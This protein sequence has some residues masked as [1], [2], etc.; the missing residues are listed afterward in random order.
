M[1]TS[2][3]MG[4]PAKYTVDEAANL[5]KRLY[6]IE[7]EVM[8][9][10]GGYLV[11]VYNWELKIALPRH[12]WQ[13]SLRADALR[14]RVL[15]LRYPRRDV[16]Q[17]HDSQLGHF[18]KMLIQCRN[19]AEL[20]QGI[21]FVTKRMLREGYEYYLAHTDHLD[22]GPTIEFMSRFPDVIKLQLEEIQAIYQGLPAADLTWGNTMEAYAKS[23]GGLL[24]I[25]PGALSPSEQ[26]AW[27]KL[28]KRPFYQAPKV[29]HTDP[30]F[31]AAFYHY[32]PRAP[33]N[34]LEDQIWC[35][36]SH[37]NEIWASEVPGLLCWA[38][39]DMP[40]EFYMDTARWAYDESRH[41]MM[42]EERLKAWGFELGVDIPRVSDN[43]ISQ[44]EHG[45]IALL[46]LL[47]AF[48]CNA[49]A[50]RNKQRDRYRMEGDFSSAQD[51]DYDWADESIHMQ[52]GHKW[53]MHKFNND[54]DKVE[55]AKEEAMD[56]W[57][58]WSEAQR[59][60]WDY[61]PYL[62]RIEQKIKEM[63]AK[64]HA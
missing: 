42:G 50:H 22:D 60:L 45:E 63:D 61:Q 52:Y 21:Y 31:G 9:T 13:D 35:G 40:W 37:C 39:S 30:R 36:I 41:N 33:K 20:V 18:L 57:V 53:L 32:P 4:K 44:I 38:W 12:F 28:E 15:E 47:H 43:Y 55:E 59:Q 3:V 16:D 64:R 6:F 10:L 24:G 17:D 1:S 25:L 51:F 27:K 62:N 26:E 8:R 49:P 46:S 34:F 19:D 11:S 56:R 54:L 2:V 29:P 5:L 23:I 58:V 48:E 14:S 7:R